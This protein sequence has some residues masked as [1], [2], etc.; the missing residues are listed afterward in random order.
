MLGKDRMS[1]DERAGPANRDRRLLGEDLRVKAYGKPGAA[2]KIPSGGLAELTEAAFGWF[3]SV[4]W[5]AVVAIPPGD[6]RSVEQSNLM[7][8][9][10]G[11]L[12]DGTFGSDCRDLR[13][14]RSK[15]K[16]VD[17]RWVFGPLG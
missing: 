6:K 17:V 7:Q 9:V 11:C 8:G 5:D 10:F 16:F 4:D 14:T 2:A 12:V 13:V 3:Q 1:S 15:A